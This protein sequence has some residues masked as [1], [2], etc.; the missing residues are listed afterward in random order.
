[1]A[2]FRSFDFLDRFASGKIKR[3]PRPGEI[4]ECA[5]KNEGGAGGPDV[6]LFDTIVVQDL[7]RN[8]CG[9]AG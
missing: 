9:D 5:G 6:D 4:Q 7:D 3:R 1:M 2:R 8:T